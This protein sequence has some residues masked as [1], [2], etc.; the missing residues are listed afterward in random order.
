MIVLDEAKTVVSH[1]SFRRGFKAAEM[2]P[3]PLRI[4]PLWYINAVGYQIQT[5]RI[6]LTH[7]GIVD[8]VA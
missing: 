2:G 4:T 1:P 6:K 8:C 5:H 7:F 3:K